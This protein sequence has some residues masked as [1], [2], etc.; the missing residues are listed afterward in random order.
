MKSFESGICFTPAHYYQ[1][2]T[3]RDPKLFPLRALILVNY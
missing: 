2:S 3:Y 1:I